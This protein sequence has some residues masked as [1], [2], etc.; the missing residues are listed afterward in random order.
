MAGYFDELAQVQDL[1][2]NRYHDIKGGKVKLIPGDEVMARLREKS[3]ARRL[4]SIDDRI[5]LSP[6]SNSRP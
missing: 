4:C 3:A 6:G 1:L 5:R 2:D